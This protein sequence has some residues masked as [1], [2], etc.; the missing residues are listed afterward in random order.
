[1]GIEADLIAL[2]IELRGALRAKKEFELTDRIRDRLGELGVV[3]KDTS[4]GT[5]WSR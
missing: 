5:I 2:L 4:D 1:M 3:L